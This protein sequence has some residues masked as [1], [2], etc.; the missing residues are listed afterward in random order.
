MT[1]GLQPVEFCDW[2][3]TREFRD[4]SDFIEVVENVHICR[5]C[6]A[7]LA[8]DQLQGTKTMKPMDRVEKRV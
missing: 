1:D 3:D 7:E 2:C 5:N 8:F 4:E 6:A